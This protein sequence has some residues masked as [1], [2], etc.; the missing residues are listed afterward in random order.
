MSL[1]FKIALRYLFGRKSTNTINIITGISIFGLSIGTAAIIIV[2]ST[3]NGLQG[4]LLSLF[5]YF[6][7]DLKIELVEGKTFVYTQEIEDILTAE[8]GVAIYAKTFEEYTLFQYEDNQLVAKLKGVD[9]QYRALSSIDSA[10]VE[11]EYALADEDLTY[12]VAGLGVSN[13]LGLNVANRFKG[14]TV[15]MPK[16]EQNTAIPEPFNRKV[17]YPVGSFAIQQDFD[18]TYVLTDLSVVQS[19]TEKENEISAVEIKVVEG[20]DVD[21]LKS[22]IIQH[23]SQWTEKEYGNADMFSVK[24]RY[25]QQAEFL[26]IMN[27]EK[28][29]SFLILILAASLV[30]FNLIGAM[31]MIVLDKQQDFAILQ[32][33]GMSQRNSGRVIYALGLLISGLGLLLGIVISLILYF[34]QKTYALVRVPDSFVMKAYPI[35]LEFNDFV[36]TAIFIMIIGLLAS[37]PAAR[38]AMK[39]NARLKAAR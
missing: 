29:T 1:Y 5:N 15:Y 28:W 33:M 7:P 34:L 6:N 21:K 2:L 23:L 20:T 37:I 35:E 17:I 19:L 26:R 4:L 38:R 27:I 18:H 11:G 8:E 13:E 32:A 16:V 10:M 22:S 9:N 31:W 14:I 30:A 3:F 25:E 24:D 36:A 12:A 39:V